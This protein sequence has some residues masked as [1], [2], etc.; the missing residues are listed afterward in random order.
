[1]HALSTLRCYDDVRLVCPEC[2]CFLTPVSHKGN[3]AVVRHDGN[4][5]FAAVC[6]QSGKYFEF[7]C[8]TVDA[9]EIPKESALNQPEAKDGEDSKNV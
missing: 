3:C 6:K 1:M 5:G 9:F 4:Y 2:G 7:V 8:N